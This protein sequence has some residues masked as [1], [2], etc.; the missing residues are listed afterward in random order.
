VD[1]DLRSVVDHRAIDFF[2]KLFGQYAGDLT[3]K[4]ED[5]FETLFLALSNQLRELLLKVSVYRLPID[6]S[7]AQAMRPET[8]IAD[9]EMLAGKGLLLQQADCFV[10]HPLVEAFI[11]SRVSEA[12]RAVAHESAIGFYA[13]NYQQWDGV[14]ESC[15]EE[16]EVFYHACELG[17][18][19]QAK[20]A[21]D[22][23]LELLDRR[24]Y[25]RELLPLYQRLVGE[26]VPE[27]A[28]AQRDWGGAMTSFGNLQD[29]LGQYEKAIISHES[30]RKIF[31]ELDFAEGKAASL[32]NLG[33]A[34]NALGQYQ[35]AIDFH[36]QHNEIAREIGNRGGEANSLG[37]LGN[38]YQSLGQYQRAIDFHLQHNEIAC[39]IGDRGGEAMSLG[40]LGNAYQ[41][42][43]QYQRAI[44][45][46]LQHNEIAREIGNRGGEA[47]SL[48][49]KAISIAKLD[50]HAQALLEFQKA[51]RIYAELELDHIVEK[52]KNA[53]SS[54]NTIIASQHQAPPTLDIP[55]PKP[56]D[57]WWERNL[58]ANERKASASNQQSSSFLFWFSIELAICLLIWWVRK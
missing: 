39:E 30:A 9:L 43:G 18:Y 45:F 38:A 28:A 35:R 12:D 50:N 49:N 47:N 34:Y 29:R 20:A 46:H 25:Y 40:N 53:I 3:A 11:R 2:E 32:G 14:I 15:R 22:R 42:L 4:V 6:L 33:N 16:L 7:M 8:T 17:Q 51:Q 37:N 10:L 41:A 5:I 27:D 24:G 57:D 44:D 23:C 26:W 36:Q 48:F 55:K 21:V 13:A 56:Q 54:I 19:G 1:D 52:C 58:P 31:E